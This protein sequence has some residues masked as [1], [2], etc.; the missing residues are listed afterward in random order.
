MKDV[1]HELNGH[2]GVK[3][4]LVVTPDGMVVASEFSPDLDAETTAALVSGLITGLRGVLRISSAAPLQRMLLTATRGRIA[5]ESIGNAFLVVLTDQHLNLDRTL[6]EIR[7]AAR[8][9]QRMA[10]INV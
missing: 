3:G 8:R 10:R 1:L 7:S 9:L 4:G 2:V 6:L 5:I